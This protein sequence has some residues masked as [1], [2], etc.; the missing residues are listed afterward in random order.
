MTGNEG[1][2]L[3]VRYPHVRFGPRP[4]KSQLGVARVPTLDGAT[5]QAR[6]A[7]KYDRCQWAEVIIPTGYDRRKEALMAGKTLLRKPVKGKRLLAKEAEKK[8]KTLNRDIGEAKRSKVKDQLAGHALVDQPEAAK[9][10][11]FPKIDGSLTPPGTYFR[12]NTKEKTLTSLVTIMPS[13]LFVAW[14]NCGRCHEYFTICRCQGGITAPRSVEYIFDSV[15]AQ[16]AGDEWDYSHPNYSGSLTKAQREK[17]QS[18]SE[19]RYVT[20]RYDFSK[21]PEAPKAPTAPPSKPKKLLK[22]R[23]ASE[24]MTGDNLDLGKLNAAAADDAQDATKELRKLLK[25]ASGSTTPE[26]ETPKA[27]PRPKT[28]VKKPLLRKRK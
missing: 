25:K 1:A 13:G 18:I 12:I 8:Q 28:P 16:V 17:R 21:K 26:P 3:D 7:L 5:Y 19:R 24:V 15:T 9:H 27:P 11:A 4:G 23:A 20:G 22:K 10:S 6:F 2:G 14:S